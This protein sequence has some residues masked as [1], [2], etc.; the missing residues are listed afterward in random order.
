MRRLV[1]VSLLLV[2]CVAKALTLDYVGDVD[3]PDEPASLSSLAFVSNN[4]FWSA[5]DWKPALY[6]LRVESD[7]NGSPT[8]VVCKLKCNLEGA[9]DV[10]G[11][12]RDPLRGTV[13]A[14]DERAM[15]VCE[16]DP[17]TGRRLEPVAMP[18]VFAKFRRDYGLESLCI[19]HDGL[20]MWI[21]N[22]EALK[23]DGPV[24]SPKNGTRV[25]LAR[26][27]RKDGK[28]KWHA[29]EQFVYD[30][31]GMTGAAL[32][33]GCRSGLSGLCVLEDGTLLAL[34]RE[35]SFSLFPRICCRIYAIDRVG[36]TDVSAFDALE[37]ASFVPVKKKSLYAANTGFS[38]YEGIAAGPVGADG[39][40]PVYL[41]TDGDRKMLK[42][43]MALRLSANRDNVVR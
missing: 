5:T 17:D 18:P 7:A 38:M 4:V 19:S 32:R 21:A 43:L 31:D 13:W 1:T 41:V 26:F 20:E 23:C 24:S 27:V 16:F 36:A 25:R 40:R 34:E 33:K 8:S 39:S 14:A 11:L 10:E 22:E 9:T 15:S 3:R 6:E 35:F 29:A 37:A 28:D 30:A 2:A 12:A 42:K